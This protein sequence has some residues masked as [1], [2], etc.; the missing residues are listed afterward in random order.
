ML[1][2]P[3]A[4]IET[5]C[6]A[7]ADSLHAL[8]AAAELDSD[9]TREDRTFLAARRKTL[10]PLLAKLVAAKRAI[11]DY[12]LGDGSRLQA[13]VEIGDKVLDRA[14]GNGNARTKL[15]L[16]GKPGLDA[17]H[18]FG[19]NMATLTKE[20]IALEPK[21]VLEAVDRLSDLPDFAERRSIAKDL[22]ARATEQQGCL[23]DRLAGRTARAKLVSVGVKLVL[24][25]SNALAELKGALDERFPRQRNYVATFFMDVAAAPKKEARTKS[26]E[27]PVAT[28]KTPEGP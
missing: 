8:D 5:M 27:P 14:L 7:V 22:T 19:K 18:V 15:A 24:E 10:A 12:D 17:A 11:E 13:R 20:K 25:A 21:R 4:T 2:S 23:D 26:E 3:N 9:R 6:G 28:P 16:Q 1:A